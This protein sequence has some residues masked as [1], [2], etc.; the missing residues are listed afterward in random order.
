MVGEEEGGLTQTFRRSWWRTGFHRTDREPLW[1]VWPE[2]T[3]GSIDLP[4][5]QGGIGNPGQDLLKLG[6]LE[7]HSQDSPRNTVGNWSRSP[8]PIRQSTS[9][10][11]E[12][13]GTSTQSNQERHPS[14]TVKSHPI[15]PSGQITPP[16]HPRWRDVGG[17]NTSD[18]NVLRP[19]DVPL[20]GETLKTLEGPQEGLQGIRVAPRR[21]PQRISHHP[22]EGGVTTGSGEESWRRTDPSGSGGPED[23]KRSST[24]RTWTRWETHL[25]S[26]HGV[27][28]PR[29]WRRRIL[30]ETRSDLRRKGLFRWSRRRR[31]QTQPQTK[32][33]TSFS[34]R[35]ELSICYNLMIKNSGI[36]TPLDLWN[37]KIFP[38]GINLQTK[39]IIHPRKILRIQSILCMI[40][41][42]L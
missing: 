24:W 25:P 39:S 11:P 38:L 4:G 20:E 33:G 7:K 31:N 30:G 35:K 32:V 2:G 1:S 36:N 42:F 9:V 18:V 13:R 16:D 6:S 10:F 8:P 34:D 3:T 29:R 17:Q 12:T 15:R 37:H 26:V 41:V 14:T 23:I 19:D 27:P 22:S 40:I 21:R 28:D 5:L